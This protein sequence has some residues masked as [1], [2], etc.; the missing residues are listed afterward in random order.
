MKEKLSY[1]KYWIKNLFMKAA[2]FNAAFVEF[3]TKIKSVLVI[4]QS[5][6]ILF[7]FLTI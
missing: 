4:L 3:P 1:S 6:K 7:L 2:L 5:D